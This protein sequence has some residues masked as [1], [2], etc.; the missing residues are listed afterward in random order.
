MKKTKWL[1]ITMGILYAIVGG[2]VGY[3][4]AHFIIKFW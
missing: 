1:I 3:T 4:L 2:L